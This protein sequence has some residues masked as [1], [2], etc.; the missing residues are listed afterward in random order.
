MHKFQI[1]A[2][3]LLFEEGVLP[4]DD[5]DSEANISKNDAVYNVK[6]NCSYP[7]NIYFNYVNIIN[8]YRI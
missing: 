1:S 3:N 7:Y 5:S 2:S 4:L 6:I 8:L